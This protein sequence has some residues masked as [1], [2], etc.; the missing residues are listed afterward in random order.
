MK[1]IE[2]KPGGRHVQYDEVFHKG[3]PHLRVFEDGEP[4]V[5]E[6]K[7]PARK[8]RETLTLKKARKKQ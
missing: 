1:T 4:L 2:I 3:N 8:K 5:E 6:T 7:K